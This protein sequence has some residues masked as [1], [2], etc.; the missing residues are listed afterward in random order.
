MGTWGLLASVALLALAVLYFLRG[1]DAAAALPADLSPR[2]FER[3][4]ANLMAA[5]GWSVTLGRGS[6]DQGVDVLARK[7]GRSVVLQCKLHGRP[8]GNR[9]VQEALAGRG[10]AGAD[11]AAVVSNASY[12]PAA[13]ALAARVGVLLLNVPDLARADALFRQSPRPAQPAGPPEPKS[14]PARRPRKARPRAQARGRARR[15]RGGLIPAGLLA[16]IILLLPESPPGPA[17]PPRPGLAASRAASRG[18][19]PLPLPPPTPPHLLRR[20]AG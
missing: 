14:E 13:H 7:G 5:R 19:F 3:H 15:L 12:T 20:P 9:A 10:F 8:V 17:D 1:D 2:D 11:C 4:C 16:G 18:A 6:A